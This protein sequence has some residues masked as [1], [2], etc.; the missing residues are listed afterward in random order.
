M[1]SI[2]CREARGKEKSRKEAT[3]A[4]PTRCDGGLVQGGTGGDSGN[5]SVELT[6]LCDGLGVG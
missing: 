4:V 3:V 1:A 5:I 2:D 6:G